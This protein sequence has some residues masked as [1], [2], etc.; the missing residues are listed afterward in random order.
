MVNPAFGGGFSDNLD[1][2]ASHAPHTCL[3]MKYDWPQPRNSYT[4]SHDAKHCQIPDEPP[5]PN[6]T[7]LGAFHSLVHPYDSPRHW[8]AHQVFCKEVVCKRGRSRRH[9]SNL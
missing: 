5:L 7:S 6:D 2:F 4:Q 3:R 1:N 8:R 9:K